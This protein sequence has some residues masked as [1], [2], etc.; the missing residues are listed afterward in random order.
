[1]SGKEIR[2]AALLVA[3]VAASYLPVVRAGYVWD[4][5]AHVTD[6]PALKDAH[7]L[8]AIWTTLDATPQ[9]YPLT[10]TSFWV[11]HA[12]WGFRP[13]GYHIDNVLLHA[14]SA[15]V[16]WRL[17]VLLEL[18]GAFFAAAVFAVHPVHAESVAWVTERKNV[19]SGLFYLGSASVFLGW[20]LDREPGR[21]RPWIAAALY[22]AALLSKTVTSTLPVALAT[23]LWWKRGRV[24]RGEAAWLLPM[25]AAGAVFGS[26]TRHLETSLIRSSASD[27]TMTAW[28]RIVL[29]GRVPWFYLGKLVW[30]K[31]LI[32]VYPRFAI[33]ASSASS[34]VGV[35][36]GVALVAALWTQRDRIGRGPAAAAAFFIVTLAPALGFFDVY[37]MRYSFVADHFQYLASLGPIVL[38]CGGARRTRATAIAGTVLVA[39]LAGRTFARTFAYA[40]EEILW[41]DTIAQNPGA[42]LAHNDLGILLARRGATVEA[43]REF[44][45]VLASKPDHAGAAANLG[46]ALELE[47]RDSEAA[48]ALAR[49]VGGAPRDANARAHLVRC[50]LRLGRPADALPHAIEAAR[51]APSDPEILCDAG[52]LLCSAGRLDEGIPLLERALVLRP[53]FPRAR[54]NLDA[55]R[56]GAAHAV[57]SGA[58]RIG[59][60]PEAPR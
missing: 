39:L 51:L 24:S 15:V 16:L 53:D 52:A 10:H 19:L 4:D 55:A 49:A 60:T 20:A 6:N 33:D 59:S 27:W 13:L 37:P 36:V 17:L 7:G 44:R 2:L 11:E 45:A 8:L 54:R 38:L 40:D 14:A 21:S 57:S 46:Y 18:P 25:L 31:T 5:D 41:R 58:S 47:G 30:P 23:V 22:A 1:V 32:F 9:Y 50:L 34:W 12:L 48:E 3:I 56:R 29:A 43:E 42:W 28:D 26:I 35:V